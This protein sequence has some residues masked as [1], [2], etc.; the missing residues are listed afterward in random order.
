L[1]VA[2]D[3]SAASEAALRF[4]A[5]LAGRLNATVVLVHA[6]ETEHSP[7]HGGNKTGAASSHRVDR[8]L[9]KAV[10][11]VQAEHYIAERIAEAGDPVEVILSLAKRVSADFIV[12]G[13]N[14][15]RGLPRMALGSVA[16]AVVRRAGCPVLVVK[17]GIR[18]RLESQQGSKAACKES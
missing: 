4:T 11:A 6:L 10:A 9:E 13:T 16:E 1:L 12:M 14:G 7:R 3:F 5:V 2:T 18:P 15:R 8:R 17:S